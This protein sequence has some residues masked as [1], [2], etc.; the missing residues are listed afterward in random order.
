[1]NNLLDLINKISNYDYTKDKQI[2]SKK[3]EG[4]DFFIESFF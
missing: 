4:I 2:S 3:Q 1:M